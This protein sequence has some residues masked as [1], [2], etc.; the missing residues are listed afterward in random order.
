MNLTAE[1]KLHFG[2]PLLQR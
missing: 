2:S 1:V